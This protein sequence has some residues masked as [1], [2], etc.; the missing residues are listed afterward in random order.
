MKQK[1][2]F[3]SEKSS[4]PAGLIWYTNMADCSLFRYTDMADMTSRENALLT[5]TLKKTSETDRNV[6]SK[7][8]F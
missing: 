4:T 8:H 2:A 7:D 3:A 6:G 1:K 5:S